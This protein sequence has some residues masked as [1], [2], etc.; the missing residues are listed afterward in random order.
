[1]KISCNYA[2]MMR[3][4]GERVNILALISIETKRYIIINKNGIDSYFLIWKFISN[5]FTKLICNSRIIVI[6]FWFTSYLEKK[7][8]ENLTF[9]INVWFLFIVK[10]GYVG[11]FRILF[12]LFLFKFIEF[13]INSF[14]YERIVLRFNPISRYEWSIY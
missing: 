8:K 1:M 11:I 4:T 2:F 6:V 12:L 5:C 10:F 13:S 14:N 9:E 7:L 3:I